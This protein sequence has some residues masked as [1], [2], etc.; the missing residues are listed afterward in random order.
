MFPHLLF[1]RGMKEQK[2]ASLLF[3]RDRES[4]R[5]LLHTQHPNPKLLLLYLSA[6]LKKRRAKERRS[7][8]FLRAAERVKQKRETTDEKRKKKRRTIQTKRDE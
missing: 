3:Y 7:S 2:E 4:T 6:G 8:P 1:I 5:K